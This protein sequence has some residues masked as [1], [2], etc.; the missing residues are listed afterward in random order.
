LINAID[1][2][3]SVSEESELMELYEMWG[4]EEQGL[5]LEEVRTDLEEMAT[6]EKYNELVREY[7]EQLRNTYTCNI[8]FFSWSKSTTEQKLN[9]EE[10]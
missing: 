9:E 10:L 8:P 7:I 3:I 2:N 1:Q 6:S 5:T 4:I